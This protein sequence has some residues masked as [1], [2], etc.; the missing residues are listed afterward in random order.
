MKSDP[1]NLLSPPEPQPRA[2]QNALGQTV[3][4][5][6]PIVGLAAAAAIT[7]AAGGYWLLGEPSPGPQGSEIFVVESGD[8]VDAMGTM[9]G[10]PVWL[11]AVAASAKSCAAPLA[12]V[13]IAKQAG[14]A[15][16]L[17]QIQ[18]GEYTSPQFGLTDAPQRI[19]VP[20]PAPYRQ[21]HGTLSV[22]GEATGAAL[23]LKPIWHVSELY[24]RTET[25][26]WW[27]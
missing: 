24:G 16:G 13:V 2:P 4:G 25:N 18:S 23:S 19:A 22:F 14:A 12:Y 7:I 17:I 3:S 8:I 1:E 11:S 20:F 5:R 21:G 27:H 9:A 15:G 6:G 10:S 26:V